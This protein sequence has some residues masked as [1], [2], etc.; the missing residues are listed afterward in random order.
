MHVELL[1]VLDSDQVCW[2][3]GGGGGKRKN[4][5]KTDGEII[6]LLATDQKFSKRR[7]PIG[8]A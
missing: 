7:P 2:E 6:N 1:V 5:G 3:E 4:L 8:S